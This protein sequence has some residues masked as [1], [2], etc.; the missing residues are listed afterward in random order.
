MGTMR[1]KMLPVFVLLA[2]MMGCMVPPQRQASRQAPQP[3]SAA[4][5]PIRNNS[6][7]VVL[8]Y[9]YTYTPKDASEGRQ[10]LRED[11][12]AKLNSLGR[13]DGNSFA[14]SNG[15]AVNFYFNYTLNNDG[16][17]HFTGSLEFSG[18]G[19]GH[20]TTISLGQYPYASATILNREL[21]GKA[22]EFIHGGWHDLRP[23]CPQS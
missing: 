12:I 16:Q 1:V 15:Q 5:N 6:T 23:N 17:D 2:V 8:N 14:E 18:W 22:Y 20:I 21:T 13:P 9:N 3:C 19:Q 4:V 11:T 7:A 10:W